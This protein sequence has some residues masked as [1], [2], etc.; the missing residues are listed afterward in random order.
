MFVAGVALISH[1]V[2]AQP[3]ERELK[4]VGAAYSPPGAQW[5]VFD[6]PFFKQHRVLRLVGAH[7]L[8]THRP[9]V[10]VPKDGNAVILTHGVVRRSAASILSDFNQIARAEQLQLSPKDVLPYAE[11]FAEVFFRAYEGVSIRSVTVET[12]ITSWRSA[13]VTINVSQV[14]NTASGQE[15]RFVLS[16][17]G[18]WRTVR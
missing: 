15:N 10:A 16:A 11:F 5:T 9:Y 18:T 14:G 4:Q 3:T 17:D 1:T 12:P 6:Q 2:L 13:P 8:Y 7:P